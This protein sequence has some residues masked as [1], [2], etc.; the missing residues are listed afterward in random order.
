MKNASKPTVTV[1]SETPKEDN[2]RTTTNAPSAETRAGKSPSKQQT[3]VNLLLRDRGATLDELAA[4]TSWLP[5][6]IRAALT[7][8]KSRGYALSSEKVDG[9]RTYRAVAL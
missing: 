8:L 2:Q 4:V 1:T 5:H 9:V 6:T 7:R 3:I